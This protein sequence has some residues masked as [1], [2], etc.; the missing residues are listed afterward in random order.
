MCSQVRVQLLDAQGDP[1][2]LTAYAAGPF[3]VAGA[4]RETAQCEYDALYSVGEFDDDMTSG[5]V[6][7]PLPTSTVNAPGIYLLEVVITD[8]TEYPR[9][10]TAG[11]VVIASAKLDELTY[12]ISTEG[13]GV[14]VFHQYDFALG[15][16]PVVGINQT[17]VARQQL[18]KNVCVVL[19]NQL[20]LLVERGIHGLTDNPRLGPPSLAEVRLHL[21]DFPEGNLLLDEYEFDAAEIALCAERVV[22]YFN[23]LAPVITQQYDTRTFPFRYHWLEGITYHLYLIAAAWHRRN[24]LPYSA[25][26]L[27]VDDT[28]KEKEY[29]QAAMLHERNFKDWAQKQKVRLNME[30]G[31]GIFGSDYIY[32]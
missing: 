6:S 31:F 25:G 11:E 27:T 24:R 3:T 4:V 21:R 8:D 2:D 17:L 14:D 15:V 30:D 13:P 16:L 1:V 29:L 28:G 9:A 32:R 26:G 23:E 20:Y 10:L 18:V 5:W 7:I 22:L 12:R 19:H